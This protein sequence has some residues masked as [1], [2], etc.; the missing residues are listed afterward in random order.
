M[1]Q[2]QLHSSP[3]IGKTSNHPIMGLSL[4]H[5]H[6]YQRQL[7]MPTMLERFLR[8]NANITDR[9]AFIH[10]YMRFFQRGLTQ[11]VHARACEDGNGYHRYQYF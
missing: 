4:F 11:H 8:L 1:Q 6:P 9:L 10:L 5:L 2:A 7:L 3:L